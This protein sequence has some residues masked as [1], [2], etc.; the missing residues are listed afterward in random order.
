MVGGIGGLIYV[1]V[2]DSSGVEMEGI[3]N[4]AASLGLGI[5]VFLIR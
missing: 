4:A 5:K 1:V 3:S 2:F